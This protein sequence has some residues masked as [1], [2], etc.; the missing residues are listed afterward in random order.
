MHNF[1]WD[2]VFGQDRG[3]EEEEGKIELERGSGLT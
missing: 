2:L 1:Y 3:L